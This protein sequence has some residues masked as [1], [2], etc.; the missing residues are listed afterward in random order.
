MNRTEHLLVCLA[1]EG[2]EVAQIAGR[3]SQAAHKALRFGIEDGYPG[4]ERTNRG[5]M[6][7]EVNDLLGVLELMAEQG[8]QLDGLFDRNAIEAKKAKVRKFMGYATERGCLV[9]E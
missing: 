2:G 8:I 5:D 3:I 6:V 1:E 9:V 7:Q 4:T